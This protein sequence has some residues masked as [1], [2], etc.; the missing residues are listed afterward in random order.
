MRCAILHYRPDLPGGAGASPPLE[1]SFAHQV[2]LLEVEFEDTSDI[3]G[4]AGPVTRA[5]AFGDGATSSQADPTHAY[6]AEGVYTVTLT[7]SI[8]GTSA[9]TSRAIAVNQAP[10]ADFEHALSGRTVSFADRSS[11]PGG[12]SSWSWAFGD[13]ATSTASDPSHTYADDG[14]YTVTLTVTDADGEID[15]AEIAIE[16]GDSGGGGCSTGGG[17]PYLAGWLAIALALALLRGRRVTSS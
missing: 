14:T 10:S 15:S 12:V 13:G 11:D 3:P 1:V 17:A 16:I 8:A 2:D 7:V 9:T 6:R 5:W 4:G